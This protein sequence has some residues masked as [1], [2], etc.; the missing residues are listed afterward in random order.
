MSENSPR[1]LVAQKMKINSSPALLKI[2]L[3]FIVLI[4]LMCGF[5]EARLYHFENASGN[6]LYDPN[7][8]IIG[9]SWN[10]LTDSNYPGNTFLTSGPIRCDARV[11]VSTEVDGPCTIT[12]DWR[13]RGEYA[14]LKCYYGN[15]TVDPIICP[16]HDWTSGI[17]VIPE[18]R[19][20]V[21]WDLTVEPCNE[22]I[23]S[24]AD[25]DNI[26][27]P[28]ICVVRPDC[29]I[30]APSE[31]CA[32]STYTASVPIQEGATYSWEITGGTPKSMLNV[33]NIAWISGISGIVSLK[34]TV[35]KNGCNNSAIFN[36][37]INSDCL[38]LSPPGNNLQAII[39]NSTNKIL[40]LQG[41][42]YGGPDGPEYP[43]E[44]NKKVTN[45]TINASSTQNADVRLDCNNAPSAIHIENTS[46]I[47]IN[48]LTISGC[49]SGIHIKGSDGCSI[50]NNNI[51]FLN[52]FSNGSGIC[53]IDSHDNMINSNYIKDN[54]TGNQN[55]TGISL[56]LSS[57][58]IISSNHIEM[59]P[60]WI[61]QIAMPSQ[62]N[63]IVLENS[64]LNEISYFRDEG[65]IFEDG[66]YC[67]RNWN[68]R[69][70]S[71]PCKNCTEPCDSCNRPLK[72]CNEWWFL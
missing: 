47:S 53:L 19:H 29:T 31:V 13:K 2:L 21:T 63:V 42:V 3:I 57:K 32:N 54:G 56:Y 25:I 10:T 66:V 27:I 68:D 62:R 28:N 38:L 14:E 4:N 16:S 22:N 1:S 46:K 39:N 48:G 20:T 64:C 24:I 58:N 26:Y 65:H 33:P 11:N 43:I 52:S 67:D 49:N 51:F 6:I 59:P 55:N 37:T 41:G 34:A 40:Y 71:R 30:S 9:P 45:I 7:W 15:N 69:C 5:G 61:N 36:A 72:S 70:L 12:F 23:N 60:E 35:K 18:G 8:K 44:I 50:I 17:I